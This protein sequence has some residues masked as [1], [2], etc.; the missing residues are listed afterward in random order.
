M[1]FLGRAGRYPFYHINYCVGGG[2][3]GTEHVVAV[4]WE[5]GNRCAC[6]ALECSASCGVGR[7]VLLRCTV[8]WDCRE[9]FQ[10]EGHVV[11]ASVAVVCMPG[12]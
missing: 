12:S 9:D 2:G 3:S 7:A 4:V 1:R 11:V 10:G 5:F 8:V 6:R